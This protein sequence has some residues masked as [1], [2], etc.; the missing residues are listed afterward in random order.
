MRGDGYELA[1]EIIIPKQFMYNIPYLG[2]GYNDM[3]SYHL[4]YFAYQK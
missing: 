3:V 1:V 2:Q 4:L